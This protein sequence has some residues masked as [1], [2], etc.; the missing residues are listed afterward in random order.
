MSQRDTSGFPDL[1]HL[2][3]LARRT[4]ELLDDVLVDGELPDAG[5]AYL[6]TVT[7]PHL[8]GVQS[9]FV[10]WLRSE[11][12]GL[13]ELQYLVR[14]T[15]ELRAGG[16]RT[17]AE[18]RAAAAETLAEAA[19]VDRSRGR[20]VAPVRRARPWDLAALAHA[21][22]VLAALPRIPDERVRYR[23]GRRTY[24]DIPSPRSPAELA[25]RIAELEQQL[26]RVV[27]R[28]PAAPIDPA[29]RRTY[30]FFDAAEQLGPAAF[31]RSA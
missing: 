27:M 4:R 15:A 30:G 19:L 18:R 1:D 16:P 25:L 12:A 23:A 22:V 24:R 13:A 31:G 14:L 6:E 7:L 2:L 10:G 3:E 17:A 21:R 26:W 29:L 28:R 8:E 9:G 11:S 5:A 20:A